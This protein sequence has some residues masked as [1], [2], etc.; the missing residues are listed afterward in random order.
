MNENTKLYEDFKKSRGF[1]ML[2]L[3]GDTFL[4]P[5]YAAGYHV[6]GYVH[7]IFLIV[8]LIESERACYWFSNLIRLQ[9]CADNKMSLKRKM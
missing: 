3:S 2:K 7:V 9:S 1:R 4:N 6:A 8:S 5:I